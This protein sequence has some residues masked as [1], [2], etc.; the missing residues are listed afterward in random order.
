[1]AKKRVFII[2]GWGATPADNWFPWLKE[3]F[4]KLGIEAVVPVMPNAQNPK[5]AE[6]LACLKKIIGEPDSQTFFVGHSLGSTLILR[7]LEQLPA[8]QK[9]GGAIITAGAVVSIGLY[10]TEDFFV[11]KFDFK[12]IKQAA[13][14]FVLIYSDNDPL[15]PLS[16]GKELK[17]QLGGKLYV[18][19]R[20]NHLCEGEGSF[21]LPIALEEILKI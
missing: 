2:H 17:S 16:Q 19:P 13:K 5:Q 4:L 1:M 6:W 15:V 12:K 10:E 20:G 21:R 11:K 3:E 18:V 14:K 7:Y 8:N 9:I